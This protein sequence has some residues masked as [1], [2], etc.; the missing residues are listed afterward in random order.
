MGTKFVKF[1][2]INRLHNIVK[3]VETFNPSAKIVYR[4]KVKLHGTNAAIAV[5]DGKVYSQKRSSFCTVDNDNYGFASFI[6]SI[7]DKV[8]D[9]LPD[10][11]ILYGEW[12]GPGVQKGVALS[13]IDEKY[14]VAFAVLTK[15]EDDQMWFS[16]TPEC[17]GMYV[18]A[19]D[20][21]RVMSLD[22]HTD[23]IE[24]DFTKKDTDQVEKINE[25]IE[26]IDKECPFVK[27]VF[28]IS[29]VGE[30]IVFYPVNKDMADGG[31]NITHE[32]F[33]NYSFKAKGQKHEVVKTK[34]KAAE[35]EPE[36]IKKVNDF[37]EM[38]L[39]ENRM[40]QVAK[41]ELNDDFSLKNIPVFLK[42]IGQDIKKES[43]DEVEKNEIEWGDV[44][45]IINGRAVK[46]FK[47]KSQS[48]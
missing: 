47:L 46:W 15:G 37:V 6:D 18:E 30:G 36:K 44:S 12:V 8:L 38:F 11:T 40:E 19:M 41:T 17:V 22:W 21:P 2:S 14:F 1:P 45:K 10:G 9:S 42:N 5:H 16:V 24:L 7:K 28:N 27:E 4:G 39:T 43:V 31:L 20:E 32:D 3:Y 33:R 29:G 13:E 25:M 34:K 23:E 26:E 35:W 48:I